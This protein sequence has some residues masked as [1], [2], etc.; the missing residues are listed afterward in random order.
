MAGEDCI[1]IFVTCALYHV[2]LWWL[3][4]GGWNGLVM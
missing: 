3:Y 4:Q 2:L 1:M